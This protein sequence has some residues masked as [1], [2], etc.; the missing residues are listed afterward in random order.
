[1]IT[2]FSMEPLPVISTVLLVNTKTPAVLSN[3]FFA[4]PVVPHVLPVQP[5][6]KLVD[7]QLHLELIFSSQDLNASTLVL[8]D[9]GEIQELISVQPAMWGAQN[10][11]MVL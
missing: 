10:V 11:L 7:S 1:M 2:F 6:A 9:S 4:K 3:V 5:T 8:Q